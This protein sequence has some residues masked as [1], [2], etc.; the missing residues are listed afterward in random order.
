[1]PIYLRQNKLNNKSDRDTMSNV[2]QEV[3]DVASFVFLTRKRLAI[4]QMCS[5]DANSEKH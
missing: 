4:D 5:Y 3:F 2:L 1:M